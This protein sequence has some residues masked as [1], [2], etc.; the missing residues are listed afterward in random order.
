MGI[1]SRSSVREQATVADVVRRLHGIFK[2]VDTFSREV[3]QEFGVTGPQLWALREIRSAG[4]LTIGQLADR[5][6]LHISTVSGIL[7]RLEARGL[8]KRLRDQEDRRLVHL[9]VTRK[10][11]EILTRAPEPPRSKVLRGVR[12]LSTG[13]VRR[14]KSALERLE[15]IMEVRTAPAHPGNSR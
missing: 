13:E 15:S 8:V 12:R 10:G 7:D 2:T 6:Y 14:L 3:L 1:A 5:L 4:N 9:E 11:R